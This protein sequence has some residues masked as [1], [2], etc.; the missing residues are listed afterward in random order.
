MKPPKECIIVPVFESIRCCTKE[1]L[2]HNPDAIIIKEN[3]DGTF[4]IG[5]PQKRK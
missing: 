5:V 1:E 2:S 3:N 4:F